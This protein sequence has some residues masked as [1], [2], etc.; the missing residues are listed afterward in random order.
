[1]SSNQ[2]TI[3]LT[4]ALKRIL[5]VNQNFPNLTGYTFGE[6]LGKT[7]RFL[8]GSKTEKNKLTQI[9][10]ALTD[11]IPVKAT[12]TNY[13]KSGKPYLCELVIYPIFNTKRF[14]LT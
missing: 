1:M 4:D 13:K 12:I 14:I 8:Q 3:I 9:N 7:P 5:W 6:A 10:K 11:Q 2:V